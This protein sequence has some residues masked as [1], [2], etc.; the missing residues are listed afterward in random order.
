MLQA[1]SPKLKELVDIEDSGSLLQA[2][3]GLL[4]EKPSVGTDSS[5]DSSSAIDALC[6]QF[7]RLKLDFA[8]QAEELNTLKAKVLVT[9]VSDGMV[10]QYQ[11]LISSLSNTAL[12]KLAADSDIQVLLEQI[13]LSDLQS[14]NDILVGRLISAIKEKKL[15]LGKNNLVVGTVSSMTLVLTTAALQFYAPALAS[16]AVEAVFDNG[17]EEVIPDYIQT[18]YQPDNN[19]LNSAIVTPAKHH[20]MNYAFNTV[21]NNNTYTLAASYA[22]SGAVSKCFGWFYRGCETAVNTAYLHL[23]QGKDNNDL[24]ALGLAMQG[25]RTKNKLAFKEEV[26]AVEP[27]K[28]FLIGAPVAKEASAVVSSEPLNTGNVLTFNRK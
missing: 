8:K 24:Q 18:L 13:N 11:R 3:E 15:T 17:F 2:P 27:V 23:Y 16:M 20:A 26:Q 5:E 4:A 1:A 9:G 14:K 21:S 25:A 19:Y 28:P 22:I 12:V 6:Q 10:L 7:S